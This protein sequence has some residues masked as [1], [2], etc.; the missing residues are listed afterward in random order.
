MTAFLNFQLHFFNTLIRKFVLQQ[1]ETNKTHKHIP[2]IPFPLGVHAMEIS[3]LVC[4]CAAFII[5]IQNCLF[6]FIF[7]TEVRYAGLNAFLSCTENLETVSQI[8]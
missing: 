6:K 3:K 2:S 1:K 7:A 5:S 4:F 8:G